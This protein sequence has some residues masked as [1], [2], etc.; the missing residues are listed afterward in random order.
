MLSLNE[1]KRILNRPKM[2]D[3]EAEKIRDGFYNLTEIIFEKW[4]IDV[5][6]LPTNKNSR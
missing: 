3:E 1:T 6:D 4:T 5:R 2:S